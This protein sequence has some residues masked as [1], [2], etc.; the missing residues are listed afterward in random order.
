MI[1]RIVKMTFLSEK[2]D[3]FKILFEERKEK[4][5]AFEGCQY[6]ELLQDINQPN[7]FFTY[8]YWD[9]EAALNA[10]RYSELFEDTWAKTKIL[11]ATKPEAW[12][13]ETVVKVNC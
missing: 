8:S 13:V 2:V 3:T 4:I 6:L 1:K 5:R 7:I 10:Y 9:N 12:S 11:F